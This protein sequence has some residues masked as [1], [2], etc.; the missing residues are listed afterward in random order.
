MAVIVSLVVLYN[1][2]SLVELADDQG[3]DGGILALGNHPAPP[4]PAPQFTD[5]QTLISKE[6]KTA[7][8]AI[9]FRHGVGH[10][11]VG[12]S[13]GCSWD[14]AWCCAWGDWVLPQIY[15]FHIYTGPKFTQI[16]DL[17]RIQIYT[18]PDLHGTHIYTAQIYTNPFPCI[19]VYIDSKKTQIYTTQ[20]YTKPEF[21]HPTLHITQIYTNVFFKFCSNYI[22]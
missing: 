1:I 10:G 16:P 6:C 15:I 14:Q 8:L 11:V 5:N 9:L 19:H 13:R 20:I 18:N 2:V 22:K 12:W 3:G 4:L 7:L 17:L 21:T